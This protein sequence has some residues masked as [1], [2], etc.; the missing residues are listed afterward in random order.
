[1]LQCGTTQRFS[2]RRNMLFVRFSACF[3]GLHR[4]A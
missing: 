4:L 2:L 3:S 1:M